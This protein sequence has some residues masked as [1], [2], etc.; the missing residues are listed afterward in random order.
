M[1]RLK[2]FFD[3]KGQKIENLEKKMKKK[4]FFD[5]V[6]KFFGFFY[7]KLI[8]LLAPTK[9]SGWSNLSSLF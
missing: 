6:L 3:P 5:V 4:N 2:I 9:Y 8:G 1:T 7:V